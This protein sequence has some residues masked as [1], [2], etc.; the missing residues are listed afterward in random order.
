MAMMFDEEEVRKTIS[1]LK[2]DN[3]LYECRII[4]EGKNPIT[5]YFRG[6]DTLIWQLKRQSL[7]ACNVYITLNH[8]D[9]ACYSRSQR[10][11]FLGGK[12]VKS[13]SDNDVQGYEWLF[14]D[15]DPVRPS[16]VSASDDE[17]QLA[18]D[19]GNKVY[20]FM[21]QVGFEAPVTADSGN[22]VH[23][24]Y[25]VA[26]KADDEGKALMKSALEALDMLFSVPDKVKID[27]TNHNQSR[28]HKL[29]G[30]LAA[31]GANTPER[32]HRMSRILHAPDEIKMTDRKYLEK[33]ASYLPKEP[34]KPQKYNGFNP[35]SFDLDAWLT[36]YG[37]EFY[38]QPYSGGVKY[39]LSHCPFN[40]SHTG[41]DAC[42]FRSSNGAIGF[43]CLHNSCADKQWSDL[44]MKYEPDYQEKRQQEYEKKHYN[45]YNRDREEVAH[46]VPR[47]GEPVFY[48]ALDI[49]EMPH[50]EEVF[51]RTGTTEIDRR[52][53]GLK[54]GCVSV[55]S[56]LRGGSK[57]TVLS[58][59]MLQA[60]DDGYNVGC[61]SGELRPRNFMNWM[62]LQAAGKGYTV[63]TRYENFYDVPK[64]TAWQIAA[65]LGKHFFL[66]NN[67]YGNNFEAVLEQFQ[68][69][70][71]D[72]HLDFLVLDNLMAF[73]TKS[74]SRDKYEAQTEF[75]WRLQEVAKNKDNPI[76]LLF[77]A[78][79]RKSQGF[80][81][82]DDISGSADLA[83]AVD[84]AFI[85]HRN[86]NDFKR[87]SK[88]MFYFADDD[89]IY[90]G[91]N[92][93]EIAKDRD[94]GSTDVFIPLWYEKESKR[95]KNSFVENRIYGWN[96]DAP[97]NQPQVDNRM[98][99]EQGRFEDFAD[100]TPFDESPFI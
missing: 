23:L 9:D 34:E 72:H 71:E 61:F 95:L 11:T 96:K 12:N 8:L 7:V 43:K 20:L 64:R 67:A 18:K 50:E 35:G 75:I 46:I 13:T 44:R 1:V 2:P 78:H 40:E 32:P 94:G 73:D 85:V 58:Q 60:V 5:G 84:N 47:D 88:Q 48:T 31:K 68:K 76:H 91:T 99:F 37:L 27:V 69:V 26:I 83:N 53:R 39:V 97:K 59:W 92:V 19:L 6:S 90:S 21:K 54:K 3:Q 24:L 33:L 62:N 16:G 89:P 29:Y 74:L 15:L 38:K 56:G 10:D 14:V 51:I 25:R 77:V 70:I 42:V 100:D 87:L 22:G 57:S 36:K 82:L 79:P 63:E 41:K 80:L 28:V 30:T 66:Y 4:Y 17:L 98:E 65:W 86:N 52:M 55:V 81:R 45:H 49:F 93:I